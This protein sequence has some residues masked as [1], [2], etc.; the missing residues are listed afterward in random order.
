MNTEQLARY[1]TAL[2]QIAAGTARIAHALEARPWTPPTDRPWTP[3]EARRAYRLDPID[4][5]DDLNP[6]GPYA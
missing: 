1:L 3:N 6:K 2:E 5:L 4:G